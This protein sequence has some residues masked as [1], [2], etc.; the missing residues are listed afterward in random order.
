[1]PPF[2][3]TIELEA[4]RSFLVKPGQSVLPGERFTT[5]PQHSKL[6]LAAGNAKRI[7]PPAGPDDEDDFDDTDGTGPSSRDPT[8]TTRDPRPR[9]RSK[10]QPQE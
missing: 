5:T 1:M 3:K 6:F 10:N 7:A 9:R 4:L 8:A 2:G